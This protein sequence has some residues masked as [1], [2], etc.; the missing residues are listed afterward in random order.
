MDEKAI[1]QRLLK[2]KQQAL[3]LYSQFHVAAILES[4][5]GAYFT[6]VNIE[7]SSYSLT[8]CAERVALFKALSEG[9]RRFKRIYIISDAEEPVSPCG[10]CRQVLMDF[11]SEIEVIMFSRDGHQ[12]RA[13][14]LKGLLPV[15]F[16]PDSLPRRS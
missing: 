14:P 13:M 8:L 10:A 7:S 5:S 12:R 9:E 1:L 11:A 16:T 4:E 15:A 6:G 2:L 3:P